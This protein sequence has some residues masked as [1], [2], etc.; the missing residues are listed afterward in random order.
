MENAKLLFVEMPLIVNTYDIDAANHVNNIVYV[1]WLEDLRIKLASKLCNF[2]KLLDDGYYLVVVSTE[3]KY[4]KQI[5]LFDQ[6]MG[7]MQ[8]AGHKHGIITFEAVIKIGDKVSASA[9]Q[10]CLLLNLK[11]GKFDKGKLM[12]VFS[13]SNV[14]N[15]LTV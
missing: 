7:R 12:E 15:K 2:K 11:T 10:R 4:K 1:R 6:P 3:I 9:V 5:K 13:V 8:F 14:A